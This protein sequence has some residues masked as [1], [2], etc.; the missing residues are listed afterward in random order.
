MTMKRLL[1]QCRKELSR[2]K[3]TIQLM[4]Y[5]DQIHTV[6]NLVLYQIYSRNKESNQS[7]KFSDYLKNEPYLDHYLFRVC[8]ELENGKTSV[9]KRIYTKQS[10]KKYGIFD[11]DSL[12]ARKPEEITKPTIRETPWSVRLHESEEE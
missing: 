12:D 3:S 4:E 5:E 7:L 6:L 11:V 9:K 8:R 10:K 2:W 1:N